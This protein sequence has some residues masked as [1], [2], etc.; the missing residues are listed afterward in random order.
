M[1]PGSIRRLTFYPRAHS[2]AVTTCTVESATSRP[3]TSTSWE[4]SRRS[5]LCCRL[6]RPRLTGPPLRLG[7]PSLSPARKRRGRPRE[8]KASVLSRTLGIVGHSWWI[9]RN[10]RR[11]CGAISDRDPDSQL[12]RRLG[13]L[14]LAL[15]RGCPRRRGADGQGSAEEQLC[16]L[17]Q[18]GVEHLV[19]A[20]R[21]GE[22]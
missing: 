10:T 9:G 14:A 17:V 13:L 5:G 20:Q 21:L 4:W 11:S 16:R 22:L 19:L 2:R 15:S 8:R 1:Q 18:R 6:P 7:E 3:R 12:G